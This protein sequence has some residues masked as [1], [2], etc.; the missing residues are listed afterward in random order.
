MAYRG[1]GQRKF[2][3]HLGCLSMSQQPNEDKENR[4]IESPEFVIFEI[5]HE[6]F[7]LLFISLG[8]YHL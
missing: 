7:S 8:E 1:L 6:S 2:G 4:Q 5:R 3:S